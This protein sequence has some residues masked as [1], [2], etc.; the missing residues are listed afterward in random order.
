VSLL[1]VGEYNNV[2]LELALKINVDAEKEV[3]LLHL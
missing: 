1:F 2:E 3:I